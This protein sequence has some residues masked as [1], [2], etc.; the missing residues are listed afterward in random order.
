MTDNIMVIACTKQKNHVQPNPIRLRLQTTTHSAVLE[1]Y[2]ADEG[3]I[4]DSALL[5]LTALSD[6]QTPEGVSTGK[7]ASAVE[8]PPR[9]FYRHL[10]LLLDAGLIENVGS[11]K[12]PRY[13]VVS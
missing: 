12:M 2:R 6:I 1:D 3:E 8:A 7:W 13:L 11:N 5:T 4:P 10:K 9:T